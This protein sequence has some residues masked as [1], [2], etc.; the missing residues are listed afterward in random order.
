MNV[1]KMQSGVFRVIALQGISGGG[2]SD[3]GVLIVA[4]LAVYHIKSVYL[5]QDMFAGNKEAFKQAFRKARSQKQIL[6]CG[7]QHVT[8]DMFKIYEGM[9]E[10]TDQR[11]TVSVMSSKDPST[12]AVSTFGVLYRELCV[13]HGI[14]TGSSLT[15]K[16]MVEKKIKESSV[17]H[18]D[19][20]ELSY[21]A[22]ND[23]LRI[24]KM[25]FLAWNTLCLDRTHGVPTELKS[26]ASEYESFSCMTQ[27]EV[28]DNFNEIFD[29]ID[30]IVTAWDRLASCNLA[31]VFSAM[32][33]TESWGSP[34]QLQMPRENVVRNQKAP[35]ATYYFYYLECLDPKF[36]SLIED[37]TAD[38][39]KTHT[40][41][42][43]L[44]KPK[45]CHIT[46][47]YGQEDPKLPRDLI[48]QDIQIHS[49]QYDPTWSWFRLNII[50]GSDAKALYCDSRG[51]PHITLGYMNEPKEAGMNPI[52]PEYCVNLQEIDQQWKWSVGF[53]KI[54]R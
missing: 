36:V 4:I 15:I 54:C 28:V 11:M 29:D 46:L 50:L 49:V 52:D 35:R 51:N 12:L 32:T 10:D 7:R 37:T 34:L 40:Q 21:G 6:I 41:L 23:I 13:N 33:V 53:S 20:A 3:I 19:V 5:D 14:Q 25:N 30:H 22:F 42:A 24:I 18:P 16:K 9:F 43:Q 8:S 45:K 27:T 48:L 1:I 17:V 26:L 2:K 31:T 47:F 39:M 44:K 38:M